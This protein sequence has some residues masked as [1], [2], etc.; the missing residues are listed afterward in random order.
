MTAYPIVSVMGSVE[1]APPIQNPFPGTAI[2]E[3][4]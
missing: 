2:V 4:K 1:Y 3:S